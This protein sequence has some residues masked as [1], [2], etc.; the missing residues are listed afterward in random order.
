V[1]DEDEVDELLKLREEI[2]IV[3]D[4]NC[5]VYAIMSQLYPQ[6][7]GGHRLSPTYKN[8]VEEVEQ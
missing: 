7:Y 4:E 2:N 5:S 8:I 6:T 3:G 1:K